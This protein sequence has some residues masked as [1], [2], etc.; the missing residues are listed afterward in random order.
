[1]KKFDLIK[2]HAAQTR[3][4]P[5]LLTPTSEPRRSLQL[6]KQSVSDS[7]GEARLVW[8]DLRRVARCGR[9]HCQR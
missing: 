8:R 6:R 4:Q 5:V 9:K 3:K 7:L 2:L 1:M